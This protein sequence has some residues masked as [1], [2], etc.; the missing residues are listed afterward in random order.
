VEPLESLPTK[1]NKSALFE[2]RS[3]GP[4]TIP[5]IVFLLVPGKKENHEFKPEWDPWDNRTYILSLA[6]DGSDHLSN[7]PWSIGL[8]SR[9][10]TTN[11]YKIAHLRY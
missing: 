8:V 11:F 7:H 10:P 3:A 5:Q 4:Y 6:K 1:A 9:T 2:F